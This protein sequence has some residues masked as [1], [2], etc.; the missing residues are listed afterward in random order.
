[1]QPAGVIRI[2][3][4]C[5]SSL[6]R[7]RFCRAASWKYACRLAGSKWRMAGSVASRRDGPAR[8]SQWRDRLARSRRSRSTGRVAQSVRSASRTDV[9]AALSRQDPGRC[10][11][12]VS[13]GGPS[14]SRAGNGSRATLKRREGTV[15]SRATQSRI[16]AE[17][18][19]IRLCS[20][21]LKYSC[22]RIPSDQSTVLTLRQ[23]QF[24]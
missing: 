10:C 4:S 6:R 15:S 22:R 16:V 19:Q 11:A 3:T 20:I 18:R 13:G 9:F 8:C 2:D 12:P 7:T 17:V 23:L 21:R 24:S 5:R 14:S 1:M